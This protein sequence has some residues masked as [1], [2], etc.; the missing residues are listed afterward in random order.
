MF[1]P[2]IM[3]CM[4]PLNKIGP[5]ELYK[6]RP[7]TISRGYLYTAELEFDVPNVDRKRLVRVYL[8]STYD[9][10]NPDQRFAVM[11]MMDGKNLFDDYTSYVGEWHV[12]EAIEKRI[13]QHKEACI[14]VGIDSAKKDIDRTL[15][16]TPHSDHLAYHDD[17][18][19]LGYAEDLADSIMNFLKPLIDE[20]FFTLSDYLNTAIGGSSMG[21]LMAFYM[22]MKYKDEIS[23]SLCFSPAFLVYQKEFFKKRLQKAVFNHEEYGRFYFYCGGQEFERRF[24]D[25]TFYTFK[26]LRR[27]GFKDDQLR[28]VYDSRMKHHESAWSKYFPD[29]LSYWL[30]E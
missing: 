27:K 19:E 4:K 7:N 2:F 10:N 11:Y 3:L 6:K 26:Y 28:I 18:V 13:R 12:D 8:P 1:K 25:L 16:M 5:F 21:G 15:E 14:V 20:T 22:G 24:E 23:Y 17:D 9:F 30:D 29:A